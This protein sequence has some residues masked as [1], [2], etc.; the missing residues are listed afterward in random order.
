VPNPS[1]LATRRRE[2]AAAGLAETDLAPTWREQLDRWLDEAES[3][4]VN[5]LNA[6]VLATA[7]ASGQPS[8]RTVLLKAYDDRGLVIYTNYTSRKGREAVENPHASLV[9]PFY[10]LERQVVAVG[11]VERA[12]RAEAQAY[13]ATRPRGAQISAW[14]SEQSTVVPSRAEL[15]RRHAEVAARFE[16]QDV[17][18]PDFWGG[19]RLVPDTVEFWQG[20][21]DRLH[22]R[23]R[24]RRTDQEWVVERLSP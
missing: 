13:F 10:D 6:V 24:F 22:D 23:L 9:L 8:A 18:L 14:A 2:Y 12:T 15:E 3:A 21:N 17:P 20:R 5:E 16:G 11:R 7:S 1:Q 19:L 4:G